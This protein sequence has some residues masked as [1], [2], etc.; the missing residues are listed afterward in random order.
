MMYQ[1]TAVS[2]TGVRP[3][4]SL[5]LLVSLVSVHVPLLV[6]C[7]KCYWCQLMYQSTA[8]SVTGVSTYTSLPLSVSLVSGH[9]PVYCYQSL[10]SVHAPVY[11]YHWCQHMHQPTTVSVTGESMAPGLAVWSVSLCKWPC[12][13][14]CT[15][16]SPCIQS[17]C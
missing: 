6:Y 13:E 5:L 8:A 16:W 14:L 11:P 17:S 1:S 10:V 7:C 3:C 9:V 12:P 15:S 4:T 2:L